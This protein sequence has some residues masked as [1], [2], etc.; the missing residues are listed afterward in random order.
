MKNQLK[1]VAVGA[2]Y[3][4]QFHYEAWQ[5]VPGVD[6][7][8][9][10]ELDE[11]KAKA[12]AQKWN[13]KKVYTDYTSMLEAER[14]DFV[15]IITPPAT[16]RQLCMEAVDRNIPII[17]Q[18][19][20]APTLSEAIEIVEY[21]QSH[22]V[23]FMVHENFRFQPWHREIKKLLERN[24]IGKQ[25]FSMNFRM[26]MGDG[27]QPDAYL[28]RQPYFRQMPRLLIYETGIHFIDAFR[29]LAGEVVQ[30]YA[31]LRKLN[32]DIVGEDCG[33]VHFDFQEGAMGYYDANRYNESAD[34]DARFTFGEFLLEGSGGSIRLH[35]SG[36]LMIQLLGEKEKEHVY[37][38][39]KK[40]FAGDCVFTAQQHF[41]ECIA[42]NCPAE[43]DGASYIK[44]VFVQEA[45]YKS[46]EEGVPI[47]IMP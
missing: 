10:C 1:G 47:K 32:P 16:H 7:V 33:F 13:I 28:Q 29:F 39:S 20:L 19:A 38:Y 34:P 37:T 15:D 26:R 41:A 44:N 9:L 3:F 12:M 35:P 23:N 2:G 11:D 22:N 43:T 45:I 14:P 18:K 8:A 27:W 24:V 4:S 42:S 5:R 40:G 31:Q 6:I 30:V 46:N 17:C 21:A 36:R 25:L